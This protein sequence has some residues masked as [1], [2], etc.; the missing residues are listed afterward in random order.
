MAI[1]T[2]DQFL[3]SFTVWALEW[4]H[5]DQAQG[6]QTQQG[7]SLC[8]DPTWLKTSSASTHD[9][10]SWDYQGLQKGQLRVVL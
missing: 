10:Y 3:G 5:W 1:Y 4:L 8:T 9:L 7:T 6:L 2:L